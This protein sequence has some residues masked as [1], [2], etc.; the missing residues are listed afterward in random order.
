MAEASVADGVAKMSVSGEAL[1][2]AAL[3]ALVDK[4]IETT[5]A[6]WKKDQANGDNDQ[7]YLKFVVDGKKKS[8]FKVIAADPVGSGSKFSE[9]AAEFRDKEVSF[10]VAIGRGHDEGD[11]VQR[12]FTCVWKHNARGLGVKER[13]KFA[14]MTNFIT[15]CG[16]SPT[17][18]DMID[19]DA[20][21][22]GWGGAD[23]LQSILKA[24]KKNAGSHS[25]KE[26]Y[27]HHSEKLME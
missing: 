20:I 17:Q 7:I 16:L 8:E 13:T 3:K 21:D 11:D 19:R 1:K 9:I 27:F 14:F 2:P 22:K 4:M 5:T 6:Q 25:V 10:V 15:E 24:C 12:T 18:Y 26:Y 23:Y